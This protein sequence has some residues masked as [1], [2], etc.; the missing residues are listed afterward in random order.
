MKLIILE[1]LDEFDLASLR[2]NDTTSAFEKCAK[3]DEL[4]TQLQKMSNTNFEPVTSRIHLLRGLALY[5]QQDPQAA[6]EF[7]LAKQLAKEQPL[8]LGSGKTM[9][10]IS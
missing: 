10:T 9:T 7:D 8:Q 6:K 5:L 3:A 1:T 4:I 2:I